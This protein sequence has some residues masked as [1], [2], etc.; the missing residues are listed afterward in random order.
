LAA[1]DAHSADVGDIIALFLFICDAPQ[2]TIKKILF[3]RY[4]FG[5]TIIFQSGSTDLLSI[6]VVPISEMFIS[7]LTPAFEHLLYPMSL[8][9]VY[10]HLL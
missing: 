5:L 10:E 6:Y 2:E 8:T 7:W 4:A 9:L 3:D 1:I